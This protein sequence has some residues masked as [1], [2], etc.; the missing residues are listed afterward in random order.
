M[1]I[2]LFSFDS[3]LRKHKMK[4]A[5]E[6]E[7]EKKNIWSSEARHFSNMAEAMHGQVYLLLDCKCL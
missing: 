7:R 2:K 3:R 5:K 1:Q 6:I 4:I